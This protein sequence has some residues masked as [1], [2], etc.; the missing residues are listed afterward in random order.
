MCVRAS[1]SLE[2]EKKKKFFPG[3]MN[4]N[5]IKC[6]ALLIR[7]KWIRVYGTLGSYMKWTITVWSFYWYVQRLWYVSV[8]ESLVTLFNND[9]MPKI[10]EGT[11]VNIYLSL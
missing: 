11:T 2:R 8:V 7:T 9:R 10:F 3:I 4:I 1:R 6:L 5:Y